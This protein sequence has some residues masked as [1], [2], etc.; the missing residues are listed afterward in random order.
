[1]QFFSEAEYLK[2]IEPVLRKVFTEDR[3]FGD[4]FAEEMPEKRIICCHK[5][6]TNFSLPLSDAVIQA[7]EILGDRGCYWTVM[8]QQEPRHCYLS[9]DEFELPAEQLNQKERIF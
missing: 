3:A 6:Y 9:F 5:F 7:A 8:L 4:V 2:K 1:M